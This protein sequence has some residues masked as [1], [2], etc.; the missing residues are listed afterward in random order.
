MLLGAW[1]NGVCRASGY[2]MQGEPGDTWSHLLQLPAFK[3]GWGPT[4][5]F[6]RLD[7]GWRERKNFVNVSLG[8]S[9]LA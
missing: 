8:F 7:G 5:K 3:A 9:R 1:A 6:H 2:L 4:E